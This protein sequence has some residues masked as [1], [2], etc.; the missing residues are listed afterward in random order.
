ML[1]PK[2]A[3]TP[4]LQIKRHCTNTFDG[5]YRSIKFDKKKKKNLKDNTNTRTTI[6]YYNY[7]ILRFTRLSTNLI[8]LCKTKQKRTNVFEHTLYI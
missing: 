5:N 1:V 2:S 6:I 4:K 7:K 8:F 3:I